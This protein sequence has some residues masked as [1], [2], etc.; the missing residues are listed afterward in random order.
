M[1]WLQ[2]EDF[3]VTLFKRVKYCTPHFSSI[4]GFSSFHLL[5]S[6]G[7]SSSCPLGGKRRDPGN[8]AGTPTSR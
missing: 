3:D 2:G 5:L 7:L 1:L 6:Q 4:Q 8:Y